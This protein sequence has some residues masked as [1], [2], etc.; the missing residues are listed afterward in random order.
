MTLVKLQ[1]LM[2]MQLSC[3]HAWVLLKRQSKKWDGLR[4]L[5]VEVSAGL[6]FASDDKGEPTV[7][8]SRTYVNTVREMVNITFDQERFLNLILVPELTYSFLPKLHHP[9]L[10]KVYHFSVRNWRF[11]TNKQRKFGLIQ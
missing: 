9:C 7:N 8:M 1:F 4:L 6:S 5:I 2:P 11:L 3:A 10:K